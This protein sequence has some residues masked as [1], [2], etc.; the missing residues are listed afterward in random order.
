LSAKAD[1]AL[2]P[3]LLELKH[4]PFLRVYSRNYWQDPDKFFNE[5]SKFLN[6]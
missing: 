4:W 6:R 3:H 1:H 2:T 5:I